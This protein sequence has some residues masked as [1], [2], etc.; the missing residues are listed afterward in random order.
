MPEALQATP[1]PEVAISEAEIVVLGVPSQTLRDNLSTW[2]GF[3]G[4]G[5][6]VVSLA[7]GIEHSTG[8]RMSQV[9]SEVADIET[10]RVA[11][12]TGPNLAKEVAE[13][14]P[15]L[16]LWPARTCPVHS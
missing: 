15:R 11:V 10:E 5:A 9:I 16:R 14:S 1:D 6:S 13:A 7:K 12:L 3:I 4:S 2:K 8:M